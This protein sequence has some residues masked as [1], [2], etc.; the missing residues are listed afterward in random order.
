MDVAVNVADNGLN[1][2]PE[3]GQPNSSL[4]PEAMSFANPANDGGVVI[5]GNGEF[6]S[7]TSIPPPMPTCSSNTLPTST[8]GFHENGGNH[9]TQQQ[10]HSH[11]FIH[12]KFMN[13]F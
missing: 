3:P 11:Q 8:S 13:V 5:N 10:P 12:G 7:S 1:R 4:N 6:M 2:I 9:G